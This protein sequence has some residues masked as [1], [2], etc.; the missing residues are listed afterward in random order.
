MIRRQLSVRTVLVIALLAIRSATRRSATVSALLSATRRLAQIRS[1]ARR[2]ATRVLAQIRSVARRS[3]T[4]V[5]AQIRSVAR[6][7]V[8]RV[9]ARSSPCAII[10]DLRFTLK[11]LNQ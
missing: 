1:V 2:S 7:S 3:V 6:R 10:G 4:R 5:L 11:L 8:I 9:L